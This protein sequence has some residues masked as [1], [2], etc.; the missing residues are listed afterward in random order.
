M[1]QFDVYATKGETARIAPL[2]VVLQAS[3]LAALGSVVVAPLHP[4]KSLA[5]P[6]AG[7]HVPIEFGAKRYW[8]AVEQLVSLPVPMLGKPVGSLAVEQVAIKGAIDLLFFGI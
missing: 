6:I 4:V 1:A 5:K 2:V 8:L 3:L 7:L